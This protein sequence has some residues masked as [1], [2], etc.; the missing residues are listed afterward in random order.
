MTQRGDLGEQRRLVGVVGEQELGLAERVALPAREPDEERERPGGGRE[1]GRLRV[2]ADER[3]VGRRVARQA[4]EPLAVQRDLDRGDRPAHERGR[5]RSAATSAPSAAASRAASTGLRR[6]ANG[7]RAGSWSGPTGGAAGPRERR[8]QVREPALPGDGPGRLDRHATAAARRRTRAAGS[9]AASSRRAS[10][11]PSTSG[12]RRGPGARRAAG[13]AG[14][15]RGSARPRPPT[16]SSWRANSRSDE[17]DAA[18]HRLVQVDRG[19]LVV[20]RADLRHQPE[21][22]R[23]HHQQDRRDGLDRPPG[24]D[25]RHVQLVPPPAGAR[26]PRRSASRRS[27]GARSPAGRSAPSRRSRR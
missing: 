21:V 4:G 5:R 16:S 9:S 27:S 2:E 26:R 3:R 11:L 14:A 23:V 18:R 6:P 15:G 17:A 7:A 8:P 22:P 12:S 1:P 20:R 19:R 25:Q 13:V 10:A 24:A